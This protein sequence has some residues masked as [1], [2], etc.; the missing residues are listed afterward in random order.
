MAGLL[1]SVFG[2]D[3]PSMENKPREEMKRRSGKA[4]QGDIPLV[5]RPFRQIG[6]KIGAAE[7]DVIAAVKNMR[8]NG[9]IRKFGAILRHQKAG[10]VRN[11]MVLWR[12]EKED[13]A[14]TGPRLS[15][16]KEVTHCYERTP[17][18]E[19]K[20]NIFTMVHAQGDED[21]KETVRRLSHA[22]GISDYKILESLEEF[23]KSSMEYF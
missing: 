7:G 11:A 2:D 10:Y 17:A 16:S 1:W 23:K 21:I 22:S 13:I 12:V 5:A 4:V 19:G 18:F 9:T 15:S 3:G 8:E 14:K 20:Y 6:E